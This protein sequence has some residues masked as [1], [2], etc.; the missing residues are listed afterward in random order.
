MKLADVSIWETRQ[1]EFAKEVPPVP[2]GLA[3]ATATPSSG[4]PATTTYLRI[5]ASA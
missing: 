2:G 3:R 5:V 4:R 1:T